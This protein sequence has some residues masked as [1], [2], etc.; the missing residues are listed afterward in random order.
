MISLYCTVHPRDKQTGYYTVEC[1]ALDIM[2]QS[3]SSLDAPRMLHDAIECLLDHAVVCEFERMQSPLAP[4]P[5]TW[6]LTFTDV[7][8][9]AKL[10]LERNP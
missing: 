2:T 1:E 3:D 6:R 10:L 5:R 8:A 7:P 9:I 4:F